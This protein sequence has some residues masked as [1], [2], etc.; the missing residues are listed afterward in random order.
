MLVRLKT[1]KGKIWLIIIDLILLIAIIGVTSVSNLFKLEKLVDGLMTDNY[2]SISAVYNMIEIIENQDDAIHIYLESDRRK[3]IIIYELNREAFQKWYQL[4][5]NHVT[6]SGESKFVEQIEINYNKYL[7]YF[8]ILQEIRNS[9]D[10]ISAINY[11]GNT[12]VPIFNEL[13]KDMK[14]VILINE[15]AMFADKTEASETSKKSVYFVLIFSL[16]AVT[17]GFVLSWYFTKRFL[18]PLSVLKESIKKI[19]GNELHQHIKIATNDEI[20]LLSK[21]FNDMTD[22]LNTYEQSNLGN[23]LSEKNKSLTI[24][25][26]ISDPLLVLDVNYRVTLINKACEDFFHIEESNVLNKHVLEIILNGEIFDH[27]SNL[28]NYE[29]E[30]IE[31]IIKVTKEREYYF[32]IIV[33]SVKDSSYTTSGLIVLMQNVTEFKLLELVKDDFFA[34]ISHEFKTPLTSILMG[35]SMLL[36]GSMGQI[37]AEQAEVINALKEDGEKLSNLVTEILELSKI[38][39]T[40]TIYN[41]TKCNVENIFKYSLSQFDNLSKQKEVNLVID[42]PQNLP[43]FEGDYEKISWV[44]NSLISNALK[45]S[46]PGDCVTLSSYF[47]TNNIYISIKDTGEGIP[48]QFIDKIFDR[49]FHYASNIEIKGTGLGL[50]V[51]KDIIKVHKGEI[52]AKST[53]GEGSIFTFFLPVINSGG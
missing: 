39:S 36:E 14:M 43:S 38:E 37:N 13:K 50:T 22:R 28:E 26:S 6:E 34:T 27:I 24:V 12:I 48:E 45:F 11:Y 7:L 15:T 9:S 17:G 52:W 23:L 30:Y 46:K 2:N 8:S 1:I 16:F 33:S 41:F 47:E 29:H 18:K 49:Y 42:L 21:E 40:N 31:K 32:N 53:L 25:K 35:T 19:K 4:E 5:T 3:G 10:N 51:A 44:I 20:A